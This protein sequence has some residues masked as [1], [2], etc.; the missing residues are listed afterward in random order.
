MQCL[1]RKI[2]TTRGLW[3]SVLLDIVKREIA[4]SWVVIVVGSSGRKLG[5][6]EDDRCPHNERRD[7]YSCLHLE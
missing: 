7:V 2:E 3:P 1:D 6:D 4:A 5:S